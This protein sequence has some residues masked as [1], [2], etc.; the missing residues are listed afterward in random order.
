MFNAGTTSIK[1]HKTL[2]SQPGVL[3]ITLMVIVLYFTNLFSILTMTLLARSIVDYIQHVPILTDATSDIP[4]GNDGTDSDI[5]SRMTYDL[6]ASI[7]RQCD[8]KNKLSSST[9]KQGTLKSDTVT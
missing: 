6:V 7:L 9:S 5:M 3:S 2:N 4:V 1:F 8:N